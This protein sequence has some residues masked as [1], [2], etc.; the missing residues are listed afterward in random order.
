MRMKAPET[1]VPFRGLFPVKRVVK[2]RPAGDQRPSPAGGLYSNRSPT[3][4]WR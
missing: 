1:A 2:T 4:T 3:E